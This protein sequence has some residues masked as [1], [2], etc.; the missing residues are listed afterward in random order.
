MTPTKSY[1]GGYS[2]LYPQTA[3]VYKNSKK[4][5]LEKDNFYEKLF[6]FR[7]KRV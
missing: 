6:F 4:E 1:N 2:N 3:L 7:N 5:G